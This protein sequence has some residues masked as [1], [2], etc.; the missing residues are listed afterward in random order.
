MIELWLPIE[1]VPKG[2]PRMT[3][4][5]HVYTP[6]KTREFEHLV[7]C[8]AK[9]KIKK[10]LTGALELDCE[11]YMRKPKK[12]VNMYPRGDLDNYVKAVADALNG[13]AWA[14][15]AQVSQITASKAYAVGVQGAGILIHIRQ[16][17]HG[18]ADE[19]LDDI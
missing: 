18:G 3:R 17:L 8:L 5:G 14:D 11:F 12:P 1:P 19:G 6:A 7:S 2:R 13:I 15:D 4:S 9:K 16:I 10:A